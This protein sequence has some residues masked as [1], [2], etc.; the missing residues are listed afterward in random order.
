MLAPASIALGLGVI[1]RFVFGRRGLPNSGW[2]QAES[3]GFVPG[4]S[5]VGRI[6]THDITACQQAYGSEVESCCATI[7][8]R[9]WATLAEV[10]TR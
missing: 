4:H 5:S 8:I 7:S 3:F 10:V 1:G 6:S 2:S 9:R